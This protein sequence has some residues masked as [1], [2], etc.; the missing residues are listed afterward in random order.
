MSLL[1]NDY[2]GNYDNFLEGTRNNNP[3]Q[4]QNFYKPNNNIETNKNQ[5]SIDIL[6]EKEKMIRNLEKELSLANMRGEMITKQI[7]QS[8]KMT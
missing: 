8:N 5:I 4:N 7:D 3:I 1:Q 2:A 6:Q